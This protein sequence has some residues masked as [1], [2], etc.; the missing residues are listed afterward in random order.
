MDGDPAVEPALD[1]FS[2]ILPLPYRV[3][4]IIVLGTRLA[5]KPPYSPTTFHMAKSLTPPHRHLGMGPQPA[6]SVSH[7]NRRP[8]PHP[9]PEP[10]LTTPPL[11]PPLLLSHRNL[12]LHPPRALP[13]ALLDRHSRQPTKCS[14]LANPAQPLSPRSRNRLHSAHTICLAQR[15]QPHAR[16][17]QAHQHR[18]H[19]GSRG[20][21]IR[22]HITRRRADELCKSAGRFVR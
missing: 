6:L 3:A 21:E 22:R 13:P 17:P 1:G 10:C 16:N 18:G 12:P 14:K 20:R 2:R 11:A 8:V 4:L 5:P 9:L 7:K 15:T 19:R